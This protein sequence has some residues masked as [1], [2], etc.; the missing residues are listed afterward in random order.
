MHNPSHCLQLWTS[1]WLTAETDPI[2][3]RKPASL[4]ASFWPL[5]PPFSDSAQWL[6]FKNYAGEKVCT[7]APEL[8]MMK[9]EHFKPYLQLRSWRFSLS[10]AWSSLL[11]T[12]VTAGPKSTEL[13]RISVKEMIIEFMW[14]MEQTLVRTQAP[15]KLSPLPQPR[16]ALLLFSS[17]DS[18]PSVSA[19]VSVPLNHP[20]G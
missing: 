6:Q 2:T 13:Y 10:W 17:L 7:D 12:I 9:A 15:C 11:F 16:F 1:P 18:L 14:H 8:N 4:Q 20:G 19:P 5:M 3:V